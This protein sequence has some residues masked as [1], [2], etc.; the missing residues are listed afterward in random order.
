MYG[1]EKETEFSTFKDHKLLEKHDILEI[2]GKQEISSI[3]VQENL[4]I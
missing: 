2:N 4:S 1:N 3:V